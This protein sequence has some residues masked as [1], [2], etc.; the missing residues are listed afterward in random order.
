MTPVSSVEQIRQ[1]SSTK[2][3]RTARASAQYVCRTE[4]YVI[5]NRVIRAFF[6]KAQDRWFRV[7]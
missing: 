5:K 6:A 3:G 7:L 4:G 1:K 2:Y